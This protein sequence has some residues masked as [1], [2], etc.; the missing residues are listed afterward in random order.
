MKRASAII[1]V[2]LF[3]TAIIGFERFREGL[4]FLISDHPTPRQTQNIESMDLPGPKP[5]G[6]E[7][8][9]HG[10]LASATQGPN[11][12][13]STQPNDPDN[14]SNIAQNFTVELSHLHFIRSTQITGTS[15]SSE[16]EI[17]WLREA[18]TTVSDGLRH[19]PM[20]FDAD[21]ITTSE[22]PVL[23]FAKPE[24]DLTNEVRVVY[25]A[26]AGETDDSAETTNAEKGLATN[27]RPVPSPAREGD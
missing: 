17:E 15:E 22:A 4:Q 7:W 6:D 3:L 20:V 8:A 21:A 26:L 11:A 9:P 19:R 18:V 24:F 10:S 5:R 2:L 1:L 12:D 23:L 13:L 25:E 14:S 27:R 16:M